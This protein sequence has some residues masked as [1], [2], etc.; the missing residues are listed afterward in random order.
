M[1]VTTDVSCEV[2]GLNQGFLKF[3]GIR[4]FKIYSSYS[5]T[6]I[7]YSTIAKLKLKLVYSLRL[8][9]LKKRRRDV[10]YNAH[11]QHSTYTI[12]YNIQCIHISHC[13]FKTSTVPLK[14]YFARRTHVHRTWANFRTRRRRWSAESGKTQG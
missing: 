1:K 14:S 12:K 2:R 5:S 10:T 3:I 8:R 13:Y 9:F 4:M 7:A 11:D 6:C